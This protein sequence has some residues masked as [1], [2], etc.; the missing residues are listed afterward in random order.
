M[1]GVTVKEL[2]ELLGHSSLVM[3]MR[4]A[5]LAPEHLRTA[6]SRLEGLTNTEPAKDSAQEP[7]PTVGVLRKS[8]R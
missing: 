7:V 5:H 3:T 2:Q 8:L 6:V 1:R 4:Y